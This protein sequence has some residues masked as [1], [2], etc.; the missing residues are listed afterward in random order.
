MEQ[1]KKKHKNHEWWC[2]CETKQGG[3]GWGIFL[4]I[5]GGYFVAQE[6]G[7]IDTGVSI[8]PVALLAFGI[9]LIVKNLR[10]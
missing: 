5:I 6:L 3:L 8:W 9:H 2:A 1:E 10:K 4:T 7:Y